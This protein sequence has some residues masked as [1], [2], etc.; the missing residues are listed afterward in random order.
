MNKGTSFAGILIFLS[1]L[2]TIY[3]Y[4][5]NIELLIYSGA[6]AWVSLMILFSS[7]KKKKMLLILFSLSFIAFF[8]SYINGFNINIIKVFTVNQYLL[9]L[10]IGVGF[11]RLIAIPKKDKQNKLPIGKVS[12]FKTYLGVHLFGSVIN[13]SSLILVADKFYKKAPLTNAQIILLTRA[14]ASDAY[15]SPFFVAFAAAITYAPNLS[16]SIILVNGIFL[17]LVAFLISYLEVLK[18]K[19]LN[20]DDF[21]GYPLSFDTLYLPI[22]LA[23]FVLLTNHYYPE[24]KV[25]ILVSS[26]AVLLT[27]LV[28]PI[29]KGLK[30]AKE[31]LSWHIKEELPNMKMEMSLFLVAGMF[32]ISISSILIGL[33]LSLP[34]EKFDWFI[35]SILLAIF[36]ILAFV[37]IHPIITIAII[38]DFLSS[39]NHT[40]LA[41]TFLM[42][43][44][45][46]VSTSPF[47]GLNLTIVAR[48]KVEGK[49]I[50]KL[51]I[52]YALKMYIVCVLC[53]FLLSNF[54]QL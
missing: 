24:I 41:V 40:L 6:I 4:F 50:F 20:I 29:K 12:F 2:S 35:A 21:R 49:R 17:A 31:K 46:T 18:N 3:S 36:I 33:D 22:C 14:F 42:A 38:G 48:Y 47:S 37:G 28:L 26:F 25:I 16:T 51:N 27:L 34:F 11:L 32:G 7:I 1:F 8:I 30:K 39:V 23:F 43:W 13:L 10:L 19:E 45:T 53:L 44:S 9:T 15:W 5:F 52:L 54:L